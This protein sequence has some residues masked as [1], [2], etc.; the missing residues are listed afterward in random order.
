MLSYY[1]SKLQR[2]HMVVICQAGRSPIDCMVRKIYVYIHFLGSFRHF[3]NL[4]ILVN[5]ITR[6][7]KLAG[8]R[9]LIVVGFVAWLGAVIMLCT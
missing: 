3:D 7:W 1:S 4:G 2:F 5:R 9:T 8:E 6:K